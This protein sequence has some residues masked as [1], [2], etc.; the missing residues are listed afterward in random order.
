MQIE[1]LNESNVGTIFN[2]AHIDGQYDHVIFLR[3]KFLVNQKSNS[4]LVQRYLNLLKI[5]NQLFS[6]G[7]EVGMKVYTKRYLWKKFSGI[8]FWAKGWK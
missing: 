2:C 1:H 6:L 3:V 7:S 5:K 4:N 8:V